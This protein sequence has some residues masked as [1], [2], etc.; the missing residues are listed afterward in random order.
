MQAVRQ[1]VSGCQGRPTEMRPS[2]RCRSHT[3]Q[4]LTQLQVQSLTHHPQNEPLLSIHRPLEPLQGLGQGRSRSVSHVGPTFCAPAVRGEGS[5]HFPVFS[6]EAA[7]APGHREWL[8]PPPTFPSPPPPTPHLPPP[9][10]G[11]PEQ[12]HPTRCPIP[13]DASPGLS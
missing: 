7:T 2:D 4:T 12:Q 8:F 3:L 1:I 10:P 5:P 13:H 11:P 6:P 9:L